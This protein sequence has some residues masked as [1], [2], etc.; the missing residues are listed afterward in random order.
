MDV[1]GKMK[2]IFI[3][4]NKC[5]LEFSL[6]ESADSVMNFVEILNICV[7]KTAHKAGYAIAGILFE[8]K[9]EVIGH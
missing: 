7:G 4:I 8:E 1:T 9:M 3:S 2:Q 6:K 5:R